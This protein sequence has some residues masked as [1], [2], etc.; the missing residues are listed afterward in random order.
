MPEGPSLV[1]LKEAI[2]KF[3]GRKVLAANGY[4]KLDFKR[5]EN[6]KIVDIQTWGKH[7]LLI[8][9]KFFV[10]IHLLMFGSYRI[11]EVKETNPKLHMEFS[12]GEELNFYA[13]SVKIVEGA[14]DDVYDWSADIMSPEWSTAKAVKKL[15]ASPEML[16]CDAL[17][18]QTIFSGSGNIVKNEVLWRMKLHP[19][20]VM[21]AM[22]P[23]QLTQLAEAAH[24]YAFDFLEW[25]KQ[26][27]LKKQWKAHTKK[28]CR[29]CDLP[30]EKEYL[31]KTKRRT[32]YCEHCQVLRT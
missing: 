29:R 15:K 26:G 18:D 30:L 9:D 1:I 21:G 10:R 17:L 28:K 20:S 4:A 13:C 24:E 7:L 25:K 19:L 32:F 6:K 31:G 8:F 27:I 2:L 3:K 16:A 11:N 5:L 14:P 23:K 12:K 22:T